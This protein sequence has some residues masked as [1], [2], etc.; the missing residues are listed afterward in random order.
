MVVVRLKLAILLLV[1]FL[2]FYAEIAPY[3][4]GQEFSL[5]L[6]TVDRFRN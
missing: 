5:I 6:Q 4:S 1:G 2:G 3:M